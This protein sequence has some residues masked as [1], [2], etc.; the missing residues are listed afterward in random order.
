MHLSDPTD[1]HPQR[2]SAPGDRPPGCLIILSAPSGAGKSTLCRQLQRHFN[3]LVYSVSHTTRAPRAG[4]IQGRDYFF[5]SQ[6][7]FEAGIREQRWAEWAEVHGHFY[8]TSARQIE[9]ALTAG[10]IVLMDID[11]QGMRQIKQRFPQALTVFILPPSLEELERR[12][13]QRDTDDAQTIALRLKNALAEMAQKDDFDCS[14]VNDDLNQAA[15][16]LIGLVEAHCRKA[17][18]HP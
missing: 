2:P 15:D 6:Q 10:K 9:R 1:S 7:E 5:T 18:G 12:L 17:A 11:V 8:G 4:E 16:T 3:D 14:L 13:R